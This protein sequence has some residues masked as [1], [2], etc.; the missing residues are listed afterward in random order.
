[1]TTLEKIKQLSDNEVLSLYQGFS[2][3]LM[4]ATEVDSLDVIKNP[5][6]DLSTDQTLKSIKQV[7][8]DKLESV[9]KPWEVIPA[10]RMQ[11]EQWAQNPDLVSVLDEFMK[12]N[13]THKMA[14]GVILAIGSVLVMTIVSTSL[15]VEYKEGKLN[16]SYDSS[17][18]SNN[19]VE[20]VKAVMTKIPESIKNILPIK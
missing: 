17:N 5:P 6:G 1:M 11:M 20:M 19:A 3:Y 4:N 16:I 13:Q 9:V 10:V 14:A 2:G 12:S 18:I 7:D 8:I 15:K